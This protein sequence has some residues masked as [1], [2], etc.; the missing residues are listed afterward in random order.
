LRSQHNR[1]WIYTEHGILKDHK[2]A[3]ELF[4][5]AANQGFAASRNNIGYM[6]EYGLGVPK[7]YN[8]AFE[9]YFGAANQGLAAAQNNIGYAYQ[10]GHG[11]PK[12]YK[13]A[14][15]W[16]IKA[17]NQGLAAAQN[18][19]GWMY[20][21]GYGVPKDYDIAAEWFLKA[22]NQLDET[23]QNNVIHVYYMMY[24]TIKS[25]PPQDQKLAPEWYF[26][27][28]KQW[29]VHMQDGVSMYVNN[30]LAPYDLVT[31]CAW[32][33]TSKNHEGGVYCDNKLNQAQMTRTLHLAEQIKNEHD[34]PR[35]IVKQPIE[36]TI[37]QPTIINRQTIV[38]KETKTPI[39]LT[40][41]T[42]AGFGRT[43]EEALIDAYFNAVQNAVG[44]Y[45]SS[46]MVIVDG[47]LV[48]ERIAAESKALIPRYEIVEPYDGKKVR[49]TA[50][51]DVENA[52]ST[53]AKK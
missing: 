10:H 50:Y 51:V 5:E 48:R 52:K 12:N 25:A 47:K 9:W 8:A 7:N 41:V 23:A 18:N 44:V 31:G 35:N 24:Y 6:Y 28:A 29:N 11:V 33:Y 53:L 20:A 43:K 40:E 49:I 26:K 13:T 16:Y 27:D 2:K 39:M 37:E 30:N 46:E 38:R 17:A 4:L 45:V 32:V 21:E 22:I 1:G 19:I 15:E 14:L 34:I 36:I 42:V 3:A